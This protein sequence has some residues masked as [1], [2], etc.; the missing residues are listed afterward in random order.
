MIATVMA[1]AVIGAMTAAQAASVREKQSYSVWR[2]EDK[3]AHAAFVKFSDFTPESNARRDRAT[4]LCEARNNLPPRN[5]V[6][7]SPV[8]TIPDDEAN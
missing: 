6:T 7:T 3:C 1:L 8:R 4:R 2:A 5:S